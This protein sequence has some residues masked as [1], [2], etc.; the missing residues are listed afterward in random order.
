MQYF[1]IWIPVV[2]MLILAACTF[3]DERAKLVVNDLHD[4]IDRAEEKIANPTTTKDWEPLEKDFQAIAKDAR[5]LRPEVEY[6][7]RLRMDSLLNYFK[8]S[9]Q[10]YLDAV[11]NRGTAAATNASEKS[12]EGS[13]N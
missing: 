10:A 3:A 8:A 2:L 11:A 13:S 5:D 9:R 6:P 7:I 4:V 12:S 1:K